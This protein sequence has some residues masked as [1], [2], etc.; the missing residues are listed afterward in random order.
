M[1]L[2]AIAAL[3]PM[4]AELAGMLGTSGAAASTAGAAGAVG[5]SGAAGAAAAGGT[6]AASAEMGGFASM[7]GSMGRAAQ[8]IKDSPFSSMSG[9]LGKLANITQAAQ[10]ASARQSSD[11]QQQQSGETL[12]IG[13]QSV[14]SASKTISNMGGVLGKMASPMAKWAPLGVG[15]AAVGG[16]LSILAADKAISAWTDSLLQSQHGLDEW[17]GSVAMA[18]TQM[19]YQSNLMDIE[20]GQRTGSS[21]KFLTESKTSSDQAWLKWDAAW[22]NFSNYVAGV[23]NYVVAAVG[24]VTEN[25]PG[26]KQVLD[27]MAA[28]QDAE[29]SQLGIVLS[30]IAR[31]KNNLGDVKP[32]KL[33]K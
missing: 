22:T 17:S 13:Q 33:D 3:I 23:G 21:Y 5:T 15:G 12:R 26:V 10:A 2:P 16:V 14:A 29:A 31:G 27:L 9:D 19:Q 18:N 32:W 30:D 1:P 11:P 8:G 28:K 6:A 4:F 20:R 7:S 24:V 25:L